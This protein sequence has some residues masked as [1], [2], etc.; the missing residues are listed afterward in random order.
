MTVRTRFAP[1]PTGLLHIGSART[2][3]FNYLFAKHHSGK[4]LLRIEDTDKKR[5]TLKAK[6]A[7][8][9]SLK[10]LGLQHD[11]EAVSQVARAERHKEV[12]HQ[13]V[14]M[15][16]AY[17]CFSSQDEID[18]L[19]QKKL[20]NKEHFIFHSPWRDKTEKDYPK[21]QK[22]VIRIK[23][24]KEGETSICDLLQG[25][26]TVQNSHLDDMVL[27]RA[28]GSPTYMLAV[29]VDDHD[30][31]ITHII[32]GDDHLNNAFRQKL[33]Y[34]AMSWKMPELVHIPLIHGQ[35]G[36]KLSKR[37]GALCVEEYKKMGF[38]PEAI[39]NYLLRLGWSHG[40]DEIISKGQAI[41]W[42]DING[43]GKSP[44]RLNFDKMKNINAHYLRS[45]DNEFLAN[46]IYQKFPQLGPQSKAN[47]KKAIDCM[48]PRA[49]LIN[50]LYDMAPIFMTCGKYKM[51]FDDDS[52]EIIRTSAPDIT[53]EAINE[54]SAISELT[55]ENIK[56]SLKSLA[57]NK[58]LKLGELMKYLQAY[59]TGKTASPSV[60]EVIYIIGK[61]ETIKRLTQC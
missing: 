30:M 14:Q 33:V 48:K 47:I 37:H 42:F 43:L 56:S 4:F 45:T 49:E 21:N 11:E 50:D 1:S 29:V 40:N 44:S 20:K 58:G 36:A 32:R 16:M 19:R 6:N 8:F 7:I 41:K 3:I 15:G 54:I 24:P 59:I 12:A 10:W 52:I 57:K 13:L 5:S 34:Q 9:S 18:A 31:G 53:N 38:L 55:I 39:N 51:A 17:Y 27:L 61:K 25:K 2:A 28:D 26:V 60:F 46:E 23:A 22:A 35:D